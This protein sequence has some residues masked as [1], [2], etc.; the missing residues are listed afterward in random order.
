MTTLDSPLAMIALAISPIVTVIFVCLYW[1]KREPDSRPSIVA[2]IPLGLTS[3][4]ILLGQSA[5]ILLHT[6]NE[7][8][9]RK[10][11]GLTA[12]LSGLLRT[13]QPLAW[14]FSD[15]GACLVI[16][17]LVS[18]A[19]RHARDEDTQLLHAYISLPALIATAIVLV[20]LFLVVYLQ[21]GTVDLVMKIV[22]NHRNQ[23]LVSQY[24]SVSPGYFAHIISSRLVAIFFLSQFEVFALIVAGSLDLFWRQ[25]RKSRQTFA[26]ILTVGTL[27]LCGV[28]A[29][30]EFG[31]VEY[32][33]HVR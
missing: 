15:F 22:D 21:Y 24:G 5:M 29:L 4:A 12:V 16:L 10:I 26:A 17:F 11:A 13:Q 31:F 33:F 8:A 25:K 9:T 3:I 19:L 14:G 28:S 7:I 27:V 1:F 32:L 6:F 20:T 18:G 2:A 30:S 23:E